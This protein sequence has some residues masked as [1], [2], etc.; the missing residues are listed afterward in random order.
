MNKGQKRSKADFNVLE[1]IRFERDKRG[2]SDYELAA[3]SNLTQSTIATW[4]NRGIEP[5][6]ASIERICHGLGISLA[7]FFALEPPVYLSN[8]QQEILTLWS[9]LSP[10]QRSTIN[11][12]IRSFVDADN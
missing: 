6:I 8:T 1:K 2:W 10:N 5:G 11:L 12:M 4:F 7:E 3:N 9:K